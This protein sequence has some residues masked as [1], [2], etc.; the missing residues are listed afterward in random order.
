MSDINDSMANAQ[1]ILTAFEN[2]CATSVGSTIT[3]YERGFGV[4]RDRRVVC[5]SL[6][7]TA[8]ELTPQ[9]IID[10]NGATIAP[11]HHALRIVRT[12]QA[13]KPCAFNN[14][15][16]LV[17]APIVSLEERGETLKAAHLALAKAERSAEPV[18]YRI[19]NDLSAYIVKYVFR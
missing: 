2:A 13:N 16:T 19:F 17:N 14:Y 10:G 12:A 5:H 18:S 8:S 7:T 1:S 6:C 11:E 15:A 4:L 9:P 3:L